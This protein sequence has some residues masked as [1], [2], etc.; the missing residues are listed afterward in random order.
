MTTPMPRTTS[1]TPYEVCAYHTRTGRVAGWIPLAGQPTWERGLNAA[2]SW[3]V[4]VALDTRFITPS[5]LTALSTAWDWSWAI[6]QGTH[7]WQAGPVLGENFDDGSGNETTVNGIGLLQLL[8]D[9]R[10]LVNAARATVG[11]VSGPDADFAFGTGTVSEKGGPIPADRQNLAL[12]TIIKR[13]YEN[14]LDEP[15]GDLPIDLPSDEYEGTVERSYPG[16]ELGSVGGRVLEIT[17]VNGGPE[18]ELVPYFTTTARQQVRH[19][20]LIGIP[21]ND[22]R[23]GNLEYPHRWDSGAGLVRVPFTRSGQDRTDRD[24]EKGSG[25]DRGVKTGFAEDLDGVTTGHGAG[26]RPLL[27][28]VGTSHTNA[29]EDDSLQGYAQTAVANG[30]NGM[31]TL[32]IVVRTDGTDGQGNRTRS[33]KLIEV[34]P[35]DTGILNLKRHRRLPDGTYEVRVLRMRGTSK[36]GEAELDAQVLS[37]EYT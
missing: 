14:A 17:Q 26:N 27:E 30:K 13:L 10:V 31:R 7:I 9:R 25:T 21:D 2:G 23:L 29:S 32:K 19:R 18:H 20:A 37:G 15:G 8:V 34:S 28:T 24:W 5:E 16:Y 1:A 35:G 3:S 4:P 22:N 36:V 33:P 6:V 11:V 12:A